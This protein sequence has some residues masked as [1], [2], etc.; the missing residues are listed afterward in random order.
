MNA[1]RWRK[2]AGEVDP[3]DEKEMREAKEKWKNSKLK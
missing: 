3:W 2:E 1:T